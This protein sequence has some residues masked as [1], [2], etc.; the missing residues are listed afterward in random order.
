[1]TE[2][3][4]IILDKIDA[5]ICKRKAELLNELPDVH[6]IDD[7]IIVRFFT[8]WDNC[9]DDDE[10]KF[11]KIEVENPDESVVFW[12]LPKGSSFELNQKFYIG[13]MTCLNGKMEVSFG[14]HKTTIGSYQKICVNSEDVEADVLENTYLI[15]TS[16]KKIWSE[17]TLKHVEQY[18]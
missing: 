7:G 17:T 18:A 15:T 9:A 8:E 6:E 2:E 1:M 5:L 16:N 11:R 4:K 14:S 3:K 12:Y 13:C 10:I